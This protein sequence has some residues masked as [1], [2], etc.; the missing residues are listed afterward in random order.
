MLLSDVAVTTTYQ[1]RRHLGLTLSREETFPVAKYSI[2]TC[3]TVQQ[4]EIIQ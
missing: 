3:A 2:Y 1:V 4:T